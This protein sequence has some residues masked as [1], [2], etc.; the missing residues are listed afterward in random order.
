[1]PHLDFHDENWKR[2]YTTNQKHMIHTNSPLTYHQ[3]YPYRL[4]ICGSNVTIQAFPRPQY[5]PLP[6]QGHA[7]SVVWTLTAVERLTYFLPGKK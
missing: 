6:Q 4:V 1:M 3:L 2:R 7:A 5:D